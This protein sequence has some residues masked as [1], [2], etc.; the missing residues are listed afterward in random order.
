MRQLILRITHFLFPQTSTKALLG[1]Q[2][3]IRKL[4][5]ELAESK[6]EK[7]R[8]EGDLKAIHDAVKTATSR[9]WWY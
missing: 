2:R 7:K 1:L 3:K 9:F 4:E 8:L 6:E 5:R